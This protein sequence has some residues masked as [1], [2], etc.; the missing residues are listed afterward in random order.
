VLTNHKYIYQT[1]HTQS[2]SLCRW[3]LARCFA[4]PLQAL[5]LVS[6]RIDRWWT[7]ESLAI[8]PLSRRGMAS[9]PFTGRQLYCRENDFIA[10]HCGVAPSPS[11]HCLT[12]ERLHCHLLSRCEKTP[13]VSACSLSLWDESPRVDHPWVNCSAIC[14]SLAVSLYYRS[15]STRRPPEGRTPWVDC[16]AIRWTLA[17]S[18]FSHVRHSS[19]QRYPSLSL[20]HTRRLWWSSTLECSI[21]FLH[22]IVAVAVPLTG[23]AEA[24]S[25]EASQ[26]AY[27]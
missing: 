25:S 12:V 16:L 24:V 23:I 13:S 27:C 18:H 15:V 8:L 26:V 17:L 14:W 11:T 10:I 2:L 3:R 7:P 5:S 4:A 19:R 20:E 21:S 6:T 22:G 1:S 9:T